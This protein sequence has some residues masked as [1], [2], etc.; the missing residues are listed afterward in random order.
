MRQLATC[1]EKCSCA[2]LITAENS[3][4]VA[5]EVTDVV[6]LL[7]SC[8]YVRVAPDSVPAL[9]VGVNE[10]GRHSQYYNL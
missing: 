1:A 6:S 3:E 7:T 4:V 5:V 10:L 9:K 8:P 2:F